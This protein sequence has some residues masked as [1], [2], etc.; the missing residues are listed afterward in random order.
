MDNAHSVTI[1]RLG[2]AD[3]TAHRALMLGAYAREPEAFTSS[4]AERIDLPL[5]W[6]ARRLGAEG[7]DEQVWGAFA[8][9]RLVGAAGLSRKPRERT[10]HRGFVFGVAVEPDLR[11]QGI[12]RRL[13]RCVQA[14]ALHWPGLRLLEL[15]VSDGNASARRVYEDC[16]FVAWGCEPRALALDDGREVGKWHLQWMLPERLRRLRFADAEVG[17]VEPM[18]GGWR[19]RLAAAPVDEQREGR[20]VEGYLTPVILA[21]QTDAPAPDL[22]GRL[23]EGRLVDAQGRSFSDCPLPWTTGACR[24]ELR[25]ARGDA[26]EIRASSVRLGAPPRAVWRESLAC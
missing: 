2:P 11:R 13:V 15:T 16:G 3:A 5:D 1:R 6:W 9:P 18:S 25:G 12:A 22:L 8:G 4:V 21:V 14:D 24:L 10:A 19:L 20:W 17:A 7:S 26:L 23:A